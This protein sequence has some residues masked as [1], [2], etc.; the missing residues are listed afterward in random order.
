MVAA[1]CNEV[2]RERLGAE[3]Y[4]ALEKLIEMRQE[5][6]LTRDQFDRRLA[7]TEA[8]SRADIRELRGDVRVSIAELRTDLL[9]WAMVFWAAQA[10]TVA[11]IVSALR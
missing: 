6:L 8:A 11:A 3:G 1:N 2:L 9:K 10:G 5:K 7:E 4:E